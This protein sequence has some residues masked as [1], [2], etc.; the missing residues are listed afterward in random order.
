MAHALVAKLLAGETACRNGPVT[1]NPWPHIR[2]EPFVLVSLFLSIQA[3]GP[4]VFGFASA[5]CDPD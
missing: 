3:G 5:P 4:C 1:L 2:R